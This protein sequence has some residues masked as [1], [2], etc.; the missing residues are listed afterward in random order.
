MWLALFLG[1]LHTFAKDVCQFLIGA[2]CVRIVESQWRVFFFIAPLLELWSLVFCLFGIHWVMP[3][4]VIELFESWQGKFRRHR[5]I[6]LWRIVPHCLLWCIWRERNVRSFEGCDQ[7]LSLF[8]YTLSS[9][10]VGSFI[11]FLV[12]PFLLYLIVVILV[13]DLCPHSTFPKY[14]D[15][16][17]FVF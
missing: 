1:Q 13:V 16:L 3:Q 10:G 12:L 11:I 7:R 6:E 14:S 8:F 9:I 15:W 17:F 5:N 4:K 2:I